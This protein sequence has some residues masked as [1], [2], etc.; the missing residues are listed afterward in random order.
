MGYGA[1]ELKASRRT[2]EKGQSDDA[3]I[4]TI[5]SLEAAGE[6]LNQ[7]Q[8]KAREEAK[9]RKAEK[10]SKESKGEGTKAIS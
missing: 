9:K 5:D 2:I 1:D 10:E 8:I 3:V 7:A 6:P 4:N